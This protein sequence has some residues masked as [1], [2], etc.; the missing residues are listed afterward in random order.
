MWQ[1][2]YYKKDLKQHKESVHE[3]RLFNC[4]MCSKQYN[5]PSAPGQHQKSVHEEVRYA[6]DQCDKSL[7]RRSYLW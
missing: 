2:V 4:A 6:C 7:A 3:R 5:D 1:T